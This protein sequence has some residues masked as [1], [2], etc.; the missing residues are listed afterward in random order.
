MSMSESEGEG[1]NLISYIYLDVKDRP[2]FTAPPLVIFS[3]L[4]YN[5]EQ[6][7]LGTELEINGTQYKVT[8]IIPNGNPTSPPNVNTYYVKEIPDMRKR[9]DPDKSVDHVFWM[10]TDI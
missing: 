5:F 8:R 9:V 2:N 1:T 7:V 10:F 6:L 3:G 4:L